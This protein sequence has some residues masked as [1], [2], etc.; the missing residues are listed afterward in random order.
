MLIQEKIRGETLARGELREEDPARAG[1]PN[2]T[3]EVIEELAG[4]FG[5]STL[6][7]RVSGL[8]STAAVQRPADRQP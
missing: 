4:P 7:N 3:A 8:V 6:Q 1:Q 2:Q 5:N